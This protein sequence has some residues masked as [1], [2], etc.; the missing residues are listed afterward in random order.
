MAS[1]F[2]SQ[3]AAVSN[4]ILFISAI[5]LITL[6]SVVVSVFGVETIKLVL[7]ESPIGTKVV[8]ISESDWVYAFAIFALSPVIAIYLG[9][10]FITQSIRRY[11]CLG[12]PLHRTKYADE[13]SLNFKLE[14]MWLV[15]KLKSLD[16]GLI[17][18]KVLLIG[19]GWFIA[20]IGIGRAVNVILSYM[21]E[22]LEPVDL[23]TTTGVFIAVGLGLFMLPPVPGLPIYLCAGVLLSQSAERE[24]F[25]FAA[26]GWYSVGVSSAIKMISIVLQQYVIG[27]LIGARSVA[28]RATVNVNA[29]EMRAMRKIMEKPG[30]T[31]PKVAV[32]VG[33]PDWPT[34]VL[35]GLLRLPLGQMLLGSIPVL[36]TIIP[37]SFAGA[38]LIKQEESELF[39]ALNPVLL[40]I[41]VVVQLTPFFVAIHYIAKAAVEYEDELKNEPLDKEV[42]KYQENNITKQEWTIF[43]SRYENLPT[44]FR[45]GHIVFAVFSIISNMSFTLLGDA[46]F[47]P[48]EVTDS[49]DVALDGNA[50]NLI[51]RPL[52]V[53]MM[54]LVFSTF[55][56]IWYYGR[57]RAKQVAQ[58]ISAKERMKEEERPTIEDYRF[59]SV[60]LFRATADRRERA[61][62]NL[63][64]RLSSSPSVKNL[65][66]RSQTVAGDIISSKSPSTKS[67]VF[68]PEK[69]VLT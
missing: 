56:Y 62:F 25:S 7:I 64:T 45:R 69:L 65:K 49:I 29:L 60:A 44:R 51:K 63:R 48:F 14:S 6:I 26:A 57:W 58:K 16:Y 30:F 55:I 37:V 5:L 3:I 21:S 38:V 22:V 52:G 4:E 19:L 68:S 2:A 10:S 40:S 27:Q 53:I 33:G 1:L 61:S 18:H 13:H 59:G 31:I 12:K 20:V 41:S 32:L 39:A 47:E 28:I 67:V 43:Y 34:S 50:L 9:L 15:E 42:E 11:T 17:L 8:Q 24:G 66:P 46:C 35:T 54:A 23:V 36:V